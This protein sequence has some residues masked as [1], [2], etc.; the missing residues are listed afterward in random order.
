[1]DALRLHGNRNDD[2]NFDDLSDDG[3]DANGTE[4]ITAEML[5][6]F[7]EV[8][9]LNHDDGDVYDE[10]GLRAA[11]AAAA[12]TVFRRWDEFVDDDVVDDVDDASQEG[13]EPVTSDYLSLF[14]DV[15]RT[16]HD[17]DTPPPLPLQP[18]PSI[19]HPSAALQ[20][21]HHHHHPPREYLVDRFENGV[22]R[23][24]VEEAIRQFDT[25]VRAFEAAAVVSG[26]EEEGGSVDDAR[27]LWKN[28]E[29]GGIDAGGF[30]RMC[31]LGGENVTDVLLR[32]IKYD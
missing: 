5:T 25:V 21:H 14:M 19:S 1:M 22:R 17:N 15:L 11:A 18:H 8:L 31:M 16:S 2:D 20:H 9:R 26:V 10:E 3:E 13:S 30:L 24:I 32:F 4:P 27:Q 23:R 12:T 28:S 7:M 6:I 29:G